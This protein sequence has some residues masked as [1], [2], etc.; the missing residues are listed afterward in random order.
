MHRDYG[1]TMRKLEYHGAPVETLQLI[2]QKLS[3]FPSIRMSIIE[4]YDRGMTLLQEEHE[5]AYGEMLFQT[6]DGFSGYDGNTAKYQRYKH[7]RDVGRRMKSLLDQ[8]KE[9]LERR[10]VA[11]MNS[12]FPARISR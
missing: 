12:L 1:T 8:K 5:R 2:D 9:Q 6:Q 11:E 7:R 3:L 10:I 4:R